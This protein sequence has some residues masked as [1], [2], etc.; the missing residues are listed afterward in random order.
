[1][2]DRTVGITVVSVYFPSLRMNANEYRKAWGNCAVPIK[3]KTVMDVDEDPLTMAVEVG[4]EA[5]WENL[6]LRRE[7]AALAVA[8]TSFPYVEKLNSTTVAT[9]LGL[10]PYLFVEDYGFSTKAA[11]SALINLANL[12]CLEPGCEA[13]VIASDA[14]QADL[15]EDSDHAMG[16]A[17]VAVIIGTGGLIAEL[18][19]YRSCY[20]ESLGERYA[21]RGQVYS[22]DIGVG[23]L[24]A[25]VFES[26][27]DNAVQ[28]L[29]IK[30]GTTAKDYSYFCAGEFNPRLTRAFARRLG[31]TEAQ[32]KT[33]SVYEQTGDTGTAAAFLS[34]AAVLEVADPEERILFLSYG[35]GAGADVLSFK[36][37]Q[38]IERRRPEKSWREK[39]KEAREIDYMYYQRLKN[40]MVR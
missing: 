30:L 1:M 18:E 29:F 22:E 23:S 13:I 9:A 4:K 28:S 12:V 19:G 7:I 35:S 37:T 16:A 20:T 11:S 21:R 15:Q 33:G 5:L 25:D 14:P 31:F 26:I 38:N 40:N 2:N 8:S 34:L 10:S 6:C 24:H 3:E 39:I 32:I 17:A 36:V 27:A